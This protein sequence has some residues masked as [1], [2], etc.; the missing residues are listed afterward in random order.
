MKIVKINKTSQDIGIEEKSNQKKYTV[1]NMLKD[2]S[3]W[4]NFL[5]YIEDSETKRN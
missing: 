5:L 4:E 3:K 1:R 2:L